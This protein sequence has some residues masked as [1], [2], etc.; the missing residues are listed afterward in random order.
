MSWQVL[1]EGFLE[2]ADL[3]KEALVSTVL[4][5]FTAAASQEARAAAATLLA[6]LTPSG[7][8][9]GTLQVA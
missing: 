6:R 3:S 2:P 5:T 7:K 1:L 4:Q 8:H 9:L